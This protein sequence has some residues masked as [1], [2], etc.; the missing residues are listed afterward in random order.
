MTTLPVSHVHHVLRFYIKR[1]RLTGLVVNLVLS[2]VFTMLLFSNFPSIGWWGKDGMAVDFVPIVF[3][4]TLMGGLAVTM[5]TRKRL[6]D[7][8]LAPMPA[9]LCGWAARC[10]PGDVL[11]RVVVVVV[12]VVA[13]AV[14]VVVVPLS[15]LV[16]WLLGVESMSYR[17]YLMF[18]AVYGS[19]VGAL[20]TAVIIKSALREPLAA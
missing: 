5:L 13:A 18:K 2:L 3:M 15:I 6:R 16:L 17:Q 7:S 20:S 8:V 14:T 10:L 4:L 9:D 19:L 1:E 11:L 12:M